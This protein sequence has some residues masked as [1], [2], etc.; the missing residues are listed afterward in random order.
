MAKRVDLLMRN[1]T[2]NIEIIRPCLLS[3]DFFKVSLF[4]KNLNVLKNCKFSTA[5]TATAKNSSEKKTERGLVSMLKDGIVTILYLKKL[6]A[7]EIVWIQGRSDSNQPV[8]IRALILNLNENNSQGILLGNERLVKEG[9]LVFRSNSLFKLKCSLGLFGQVLDGLGENKISDQKTIK[10]SSS[11]VEQKATG[12]IDREPVRIPLRTGI[13][14]IDSL[15]P[16]GRGQRELIIGDRQTGKSSVALDAILNHVKLNNRYKFKN[17]KSTLADLRNI[18]WFVYNAIGQKQ[19]TVN[20]FRESLIKYDAFWFTSIVA[21]TA[22]EPAPLQFL[23]PYTACT[24]GEFIRDVVGGHCTI[25]YDD[26]SKH[27][28]AYRQMSLLLRRPPGREAFPGDVF[29]VHSRLLERAGSLTVTKKQVRGTLT[30]FPIIETQA[31]D[32]SAYIPTNVISITDGQIFLET[33]LFYRGIRPAVNVGLSVSRVGSAAQPGIMKRVAGSLKMELA[34]YREIE[35]FSKLGAS[36]DEQTQKIL[37]RGENLIE[38]LKQNLHVPLTTIEQVLS[39][40]L[41]VGY[42]GGWLNDVSKVKSKKNVGS[43][44]YSRIRVRTSWLEWFRMLS[45]DFNIFQVSPF[46]A[47]LLKFSETLGITDLNLYNRS[48]NSLLN[49]FKIHPIVFFDDIIVSF[50]KETSIMNATT[51]NSTSLLSNTAYLYNLR[52]TKNAE[53]VVR[54]KAKLQNKRKAGNSSLKK[55]SIRNLLIQG[56]KFKK[57]KNNLAKILTVWAKGNLF[58][59]K[60]NKKV[61]EK[62]TKNVFPFSNTLLNTFEIFLNFAVLGADKQFAKNSNYLRITQNNKFAKTLKI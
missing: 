20:Q 62:G 21:S 9:A 48:E 26:L 18:V 39:I 10:E 2:K 17:K 45:S 59:Q 4:N 55:L 43:N 19:S 24:L 23:S 47:N 29:Y 46:I 53:K 12:I 58:K 57:T 1:F 40:Y 41:G 38:I 56:L 25:I 28:V 11:L 22:A 13:K 32:V 52:Y 37:N 54:V 30:A 60:F 6:K 16:I 33:E 14:S 50:L 7:G 49:L 35:G 51:A 34:Q 36:L 61:V 31:G 8:Y 15:V 27:A 5:K 3:S 44:L 42:S